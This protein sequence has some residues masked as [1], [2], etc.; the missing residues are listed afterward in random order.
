MSIVLDLPPEL[1]SVLA[2]EAARLRLPLSEYAARLL[3]TGRNSSAAKPSNGAELLL[4][5]QNEGLIGSRPEIDD[6]AEYARH[7]RKQ[8][9]TRERP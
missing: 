9:E 1:E 6:A 7:L 8:S 5:W 4:Y 3:V 2:A